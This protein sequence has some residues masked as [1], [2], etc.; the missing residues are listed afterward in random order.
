MKYA[1]MDA[2]VEPERH[3][4]EQCRLAHMLVEFDIAGD[5]EIEIFGRVRRQEETS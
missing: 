3:A 5:A 2:S 1:Y 4:K